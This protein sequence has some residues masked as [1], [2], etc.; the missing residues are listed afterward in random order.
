MNETTLRAV[1]F[2]LDGVLIHS[3]EV[4]FHLLDGCARDLGYAPVTRERFHPTWGQG[5]EADVAS[6]FP[7]HTIPQIEG[8]YHAHFMD[9]AAHL[10]VTAHAAEVFAELRAR[11][12]ALAVI[13]NTPSPLAADI[14]ARAG[15]APDTLVGGTDVPAAKP[16]PDMVEE[17]M[18][19][20]GVRAPQAWVVGDSRYDREAAAAAGVRF[21]GLGGIAGDDTIAELTELLGLLPPHA[22]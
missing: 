4:W 1:L 22:S 18:R 8:Y 13:T 15:L 12:L 11:G 10:V 21:I 7:R 16:A 2:D 6:F 9:H 5:I 17:A 3:Y 20:L 14:L 19:R